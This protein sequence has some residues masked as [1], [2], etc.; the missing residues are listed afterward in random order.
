MNSAQRRKTRR[1]FSHVVAMS[2]GRHQQFVEHDAQ[3]AQ[4]AKW[5][6][7]QFG[8]YSCRI[9]VCW[10]RT[11]FKFAREQDAI[12]FALRWS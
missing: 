11:E 9:I 4:A 3:V 6:S 7:K 1:K 10:S 12:L 2:V 5:C 8:K